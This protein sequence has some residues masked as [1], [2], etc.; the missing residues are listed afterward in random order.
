MPFVTE[1]AWQYLT[2]RVAAGADADALMVAAYPEP[3]DA[4]RDSDAEQTIATLREIIIGIRNIR[5]EYKVEPAKFVPATI[6]STTAAQLETQRAL[7]ARMARLDTAQLTIVPSIGQRPKAAATLVI[8]DIEVFVPLAGLID[9]DAERQRLRRDLDA[10]VADAERKRT[11][12]NDASFT[13]KAPAA[14]VQKERDFLANLEAQ[15]TRLSQRLE[16][17]AAD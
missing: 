6:V 9:L 11:R 1:E 17:Y 13:G 12:L 16:E 2:G 4:L 14:V 3:G 15:I 10:A 5:A 7:L 8:G